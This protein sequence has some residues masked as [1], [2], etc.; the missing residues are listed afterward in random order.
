[1]R[2]TIK[3]VAFI[4][5]GTLAWTMT[6][7]ESSAQEVVTDE[8]GTEY[9][10]EYL[11]INTQRNVTETATSLELGGEGPLRVKPGGAF[12]LNPES[13]AGVSSEPLVNSLRGIVVVPTPGDV[14]LDGWPGVEGIWHDYDNFPKKVGN[15]LTSYLGKP[16]SLASLDE[17]IKAT[18][19]AYRSS[20]RPVVDVMLPEQDITSGVVQL[21]VVEG[22]LNRIRVEGV[23]ADT[24]EYLRR[25]VSLKQGDVIN[26][27][28]VLRNLNWL[29]RS[30]YRKVDL[31]YAPGYEFGTTDIIL[32]TLESDPTFVYF[33]Y[34]DS[35]TQALGLNRYLVGFNWGDAFGPDQGLSY[36]FTTGDDIGSIS[37]HSAAYTGLLP[38]QHFLVVAG[39]YGSVDAGTEA[40]GVTLDSGGANSQAT[41]RYG[42]PI[43]MF[44]SQNHELKLGFDF[45]STNNNLAFGGDEIFDTTT[46]IFQFSLGYSIVAQDRW[47]LTTADV[48]GFYSPGGMNGDNSDEAFQEARND[49]HADYAYG[50]LGIERQQRL[51]HDWT[52]RLRG[53]GQISNGNLLA[54]EQLGVGGYDTVR[55]FDNRIVRGDEGFWG[56]VE[57]FTPAT[58]IGRFMK[59]KNETDELRFLAFLDYGDVGNVDRVQDEPSSFQMSSVGGGLRWRYSD[60]F[61]VRLDYGFP[62]STKN[63]DAIDSSGRFHIGATANF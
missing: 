59:W 49:S 10:K 38:W 21:V 45:K 33:G 51:G 3:T 2:R 19:R 63:L 61:R 23:D 46:E 16:V 47:G 41:V 28:D 40:G 18:I 5:A 9:L 22:K 15:V 6:L 62:I 53:Q 54:S 56:T 58:S 34:E 8:F 7:A 29:N 11:P 37:S 35:G 36:Q 17:M 44:K 27:K 43:N 25:Q 13:Q 39:S 30:P 57:V 60:W 48:T 14:R 12:V 20:D 1:M 31:A 50:A 42:I 32:N 55:G 52:L 4:A 24:E 26:N